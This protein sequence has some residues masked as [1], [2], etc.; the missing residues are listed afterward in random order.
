VDLITGT[1]LRWL[2]LLATIGVWVALPGLRAGPP[3]PDNRKAPRPLPREGPEPGAFSRDCL[4]PEEL[5]FGCWRTAN[6]TEEL[7]AAALAGDE[8][9]DQLAAARALW[10]GRSRRQAA[11]VLKFLAGP[12]PGGDGFRALQREAEAALRPAPV[13]K[14]LTEGDY[15]WG[16]WL[17]F[18]RPHKDFV[19][20]LLAAL[21]DRPRYRAE[22]VLALGNSG[23]PRALEPLLAL[24]KA[25][26]YEPPGEA[27]QALGYLGDPKAEP[28]LIEALAADNNWRQAQACG[29][30]ARLGTRKALPA[31]EKLAKDERPTG[32]VNVSG[33]AQYAVEQI[34]RREKR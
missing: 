18:L 25:K 5:Q 31:L 13:L 6:D 11:N 12:P 33:M 34:A 19:P 28:A 21:K 20:T 4:E 8:P 26:D 32:A 17:A 2:I 22:T 27:A 7:Y 30:L 24:L 3:D 23:D 9:D 1:V 29:A 16:A 14:E 10:L 15:K